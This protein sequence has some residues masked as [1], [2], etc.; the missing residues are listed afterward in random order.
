MGWEHIHLI[1][2]LSLPHVEKLILFALASR[3]DDE[4]KC[5]PSIE[6]IC[7]DTGLK[8]RAAQIHLKVLVQRGYVMRD[9]RPGRASILRLNL[10]ILGSGAP[11][12]P[13]HEPHA[14]MHAM[15][16]TRAGRAPEV[17]I[18]LPINGPWKSYPQ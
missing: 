4:G 6:L 10:R 8:H 17:A 12:T 1:R 5:W 9:D 7:R 14:A 13:L 3:I 11:E 16:D 15:H 2:E 18:E